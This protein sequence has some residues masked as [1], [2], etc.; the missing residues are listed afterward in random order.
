MIAILGAMNEEITPI[1]NRLQGY[2]VIE[3][4]GNKFYTS[5]YNGKDIVVA[6]S[7]IGK[8]NAAL[9]ASILI[10]KFKAEKLLFTGVAGALANGL[11]IGDLLFAT[12]L[13][14]HD[15]DITDFGH[16]YGYVPGIEI[17]T[18]TD[19]GLNEIA[20][21]V[22]KK[23]AIDLKSG[24]IATGDQFVCRQEKKDWIKN[25]FN[26]SAVEMEGASVAQVCTQLDVPF[27][28]MRAISDEASG[29]ATCDFDEFLHTS[30]EVSADFVLDM[31]SQL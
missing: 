16:P 15:L 1:L 22:A 18:K 29:D 6:Y 26:A 28:M 25:T 13:V 31:V 21:S 17:F 10:Q 27:F 19:E 7:K 24:I 5:N 11:K 23:H 3:Y 12:S 20:K 2:E 9:T 8:V 14:Q 4:A 30:A